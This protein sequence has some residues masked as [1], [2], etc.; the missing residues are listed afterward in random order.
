ME[1]IVSV[2]AF[3]FNSFTL[4]SLLHPSVQAYIH[5]TTHSYIHDCIHYQGSSGECCEI[6]GKG[7][8]GDSR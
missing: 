1:R 8:E 5:T 2:V 7:L 6:G 4:S 3:Q